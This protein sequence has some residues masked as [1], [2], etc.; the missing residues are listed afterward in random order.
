MIPIIVQTMQ[1]QITSL[2][3]LKE[4]G[5]DLCMICGSISESASGN[6]REKKTI[7]TA[8]FGADI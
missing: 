2:N 7:K 3:D 6:Y 4:Y 1:C 5:T 8:S